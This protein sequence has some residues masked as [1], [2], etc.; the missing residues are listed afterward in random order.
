MMPFVKDLKDDDLS[1]LSK[2][3]GSL[4]PKASGE[5]VDPAQLQ[6]GAELV[7]A[8]RC[9]SCHLPTLAGQEQ[10]PRIAKQ[11]IDYLI[12]ALKAFRD[13]TRSGA[14]T[15]MSASVAGMSDADFVALAHYAASR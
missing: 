1:G 2:H 7:Q 5:A 11:R 4:A 9:G 13:G 6:R 15:L 14:E 3:F 10:A 12:Y 8:R